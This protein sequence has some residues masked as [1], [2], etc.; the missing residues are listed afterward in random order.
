MI[1]KIVLKQDKENNYIY[2]NYD[3]ICYGYLNREEVKERVPNESLLMDEHDSNYV[4][5]FGRR[6]GEAFSIITNGVCYLLND[7]GKTIERIN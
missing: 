6:N 7:Y 3:S 4:Q 1:V 5:L 2:D